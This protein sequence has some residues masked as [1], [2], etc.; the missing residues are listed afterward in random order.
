MRVGSA[1]L[2]IA[3]ENMTV[4]TNGLTNTHPICHC[5][6]TYLNITQTDRAHYRMDTTITRPTHK[7]IMH[8]RTHGQLL[9]TICWVPV[10]PNKDPIKPIIAI[11]QM[12]TGHQILI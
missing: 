7:F 4:I 10:T 6:P 12:Q 8:R 2:Y 9:P 5:W 11:I 1:I 3:N